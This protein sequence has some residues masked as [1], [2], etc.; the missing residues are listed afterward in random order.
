MGVGRFASGALATWTLDLAGRG[1]ALFTRR[2]HGTGGSLAIPNDRT[3]EP[4][5][6][7]MSRNGTSHAVIP[8]EQLALAPDF[9]LDATTAALFGG[10]R[11]ASYD[12]PWADI[13][14]NLLG[15]ELDDFARAITDRESPE[16]SGEMGLR[17]LAIAYG[18]LESERSGRVLD[19]E[20]IL[21]GRATPYQDAIEAALAGRTPTHR[22]GR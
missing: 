20:E 3:G 5:A 4:L 6:L 15:I 18:F 11:L 10:E 9:R 19:V 12:L 8:A 2:V 22:I 13:D 17:S 16:V 7:T 14:A 1:E 21:D